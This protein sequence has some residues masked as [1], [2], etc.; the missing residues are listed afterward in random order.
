[1]A[2]PMDISSPDHSRKRSLPDDDQTSV[3]KSESQVPTPPLTAS[4]A[5]KDSIRQA[6]PAPSSSALS[7][8]PSGANDQSTDPNAPPKKRRKYTPAE[9][10]QRRLEKE[11]KDKERAELK[12]KRD[13]EKQKKDEEKRRKNEEKEAKQREKD[14]KKAREDEEKEKK[15]R[16][17]PKIASFFKMPSSQ[18]SPA[19]STPVQPSPARQNSSNSQPLDADVP[20][21]SP[22]PKRSPQQSQSDYRKMFLPFQLKAHTK[23]APYVPAL[24]PDELETSQKE[25]DKVLRRTTI[26]ASPTSSYN[27]LFAKERT[28]SRGL[29]QPTARE[30]IESLQQGSSQVPVDLTDESGEHYR[31]TDLLDSLIVRYLHFGEDVRPAYFGT[32]SRKISSPNASKL[33]KNP[34]SK[35]RKDTDYDYDSEAEWE[36]PEEGEDIGSDGEED[37]ESVGDAEEMDEFLEDDAADSKRHMITGDLKPVST[38]LCWED[39]K[40]LSKSSTEESSVDLDSMKID[41][42][43]PSYWQTPSTP[44]VIVAKASGGQMQLDGKMKPPKVPLMP[45]SNTND[46]MTII[47]ASSGMKG[48]I[49]SVASTKAAKPAPKP[50]QGP[51]LAEFKDAVDGSNLTKV[52]LLKALKKRFPKHTNDTIK[53][54]LSSCF[55]RIG[56]YEA[57]KVWKAVA[58]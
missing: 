9:Q 39:A 18:K 19:V 33:R 23:C 3:S 38:G 11:Q 12:V 28:R 31:P 16:A 15:A 17:Q 58:A 14:L 27:T 25:M 10:E 32:Y 13:E 45:R 29:W 24:N 37:E 22:T 20:M 57:D 6:S 42:F 52:D 5:N 55:A 47:G 8:A 41:F 54:T 49:M 40:G 43:I 56:Q 48:P 26:A 36:E 4:P 51:E 1:M 50:L 34:F 53:A 30:V 7:S 21:A 2:E 44:A 46:T 35:L